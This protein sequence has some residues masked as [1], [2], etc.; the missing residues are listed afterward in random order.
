[1]RPLVSIALGVKGH[2][3]AEPVMNTAHREGNPRS[4]GK[5]GIGCGTEAK[6]AS[7]QRRHREGRC[8]D[9]T[10]TATPKRQLGTGERVCCTGMECA[11]ILTLSEL[12]SLGTVL[13]VGSAVVTWGCVVVSDGGP[14]ATPTAN[15]EK[16]TAEASV[17]AV[18]LCRGVTRAFGSM[19]S[20]ATCGTSRAARVWLVCAST[21]S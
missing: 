13:P 18:A 15:P 3:H 1:M 6:R 21:R 14:A 17:V 5:W 16:R 4:A 7:G 19:G 11:S 9:D 8:Y 2:D 12:R 20:L 10:K